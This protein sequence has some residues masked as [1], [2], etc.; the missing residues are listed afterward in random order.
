MALAVIRFDLRSA[1]WSPVARAELYAACL[2][3]ARYADEHG[4]DMLVLSEHHGDPD[5]YLPSPLVL[6]GAIAGRTERIPMFVSALLV[7]LHD[8]IRLAEDLAVLDLVSRG[9]VTYVTGIGYRPGEYHLLRKDFHR[10]GKLLDESLEVMLQAWTGEPFEYHGETVQVLPRPYSD[11]H[12]TIFIGGSAPVSA[13]R[14]ARY[15]F[16]FFPSAEDPKLAEVYR[17]ECERLGKDPGMVMMPSGPVAV[18][19]SEDPDRT[20][21]EIGEYLLDDAMTYSS[22]LTDDMRSQAH[23]EATTVEDLRAEG[24]Y[25]VVTPDECVALADEVG[26]FGGI[27]LHP[28][29]GGTPLEHGWQSLELFTSKVLPRLR[30]S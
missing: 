23:A 4:F 12:P 27:V 1:A 24:V 16:G 5:G 2:D 17:E 11:P 13:K 29:C 22:H 15:G 25:R 3:Q 19:V 20:W 28:L 9:R 7:P 14:A 21:A 8:P 18:F 6:G 10:R 30:G 26:P